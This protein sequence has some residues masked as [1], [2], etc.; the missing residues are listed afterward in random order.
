MIVLR[1]VHIFDLWKLTLHIAGSCAI[2]TPTPHLPHHALHHLGPCPSHLSLLTP[3]NY[4][5]NTWQW[6]RQVQPGCLSSNLPDIPPRLLDQL[7]QCVRPGPRRYHHVGVVQDS[8]GR[9][10]RR[11]GRGGRNIKDTRYTIHFIQLRY[12]CWNKTVH[13]NF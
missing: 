3:L 12:L 2:T 13:P 9:R 4:S 1:W 5:W 11:G 8:I 6:H 10:G 7:P